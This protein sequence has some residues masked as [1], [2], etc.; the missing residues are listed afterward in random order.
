MKAN[1]R[2]DEYLTLGYFLNGLLDVKFE[3]CL[4]LLRHLY[5]RCDC[6]PPFL[7]WV[8]KGDLTMIVYTKFNGFLTAEYFLNGL[9]ILEVMV[10]LF[11]N[12]HCL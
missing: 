10:S 9:L 1:A 2:F 11:F 6:V 7:F 12:I 4:P 5:G 3:K 8:F